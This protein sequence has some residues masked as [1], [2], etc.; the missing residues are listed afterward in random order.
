MFFK[1]LFAPTGDKRE[2]K[3]IQT[4]T[5]RWYSRYGQFSGDIRE[6]C[7]V[8]ISEEEANHFAEQLESAFKLLKHTS[9]TSVKVKKNT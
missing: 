3:T 8:F 1:K 2:L 5:V 4:W 6:E 7:E 9:G